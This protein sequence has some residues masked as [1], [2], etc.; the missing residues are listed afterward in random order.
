M[1][2]TRKQIR[3]IIRESLKNKKLIIE[4]D[5]DPEVDKFDDEEVDLDFDP[6]DISG[7]NVP[8]G[9]K[10]LLDPDISAVKFMDLDAQLDDSG[11]IQHQAFAIAA[12]ALTY[13]DNDPTQTRELLKKAIQ[14]LPKILKG[15]E[16]ESKPKDPEEDK[17][18][19][20]SGEVVVD[21]APVF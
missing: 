5:N 7:V 12:F 14:L 4:K 2:I 20:S 10:R 19:D 21:K 1:K 18:A 9:L 17:E 6:G 8:A 11:S 16:G 13:A 15:Y 3:D